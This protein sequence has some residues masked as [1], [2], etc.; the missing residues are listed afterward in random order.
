MLF[1]PVA[2][3]MDVLVVVT[4]TVIAHVPEIVV[5]L[6]LMIVPV[7][8]VVVLD[9]PELVRAVVLVTAIQAV[10]LAVPV[11][12]LPV[13]DPAL[14]L[15]ILLA[16]PLVPMTALADAKEP[17]QVDVV[18]LVIIHAAFLVKLHVIINCTA[19]CS[20]SSVYGGNSEKSVLNFAYTG[21][22]QS[23]TLEPGKYVLECWGA[24]G[25]YR[26]NSSYGGKVAILQ[27][28]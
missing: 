27:E 10:I 6:V 20:V 26:S 8:L 16:L 18:V 13:L 19:V 15:V 7:V 14:V 17:V 21:K 23:V 3:M 1:V 5:P 24:Q 25:G 28:L 2:V 9:V 11:V 22:A 4:G 12:I